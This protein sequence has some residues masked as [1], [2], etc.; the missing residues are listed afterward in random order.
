MKNRPV[1]SPPALLAASII[2][3]LSAASPLQAQQ[4]RFAEASDLSENTDAVSG[5]RATT[6]APVLVTG[7][8][9]RETAAGG[10]SPVIVFEREAI[11]RVGVATLQQFFE[12]LP[13]NFGGGA[14]GANVANLGLDRDTG[15]NFGQGTSI[16]LR[17]LGTGTTL[18]LINGH[19]IA[20]SNRYQYVDVSLIP[21]S[22]VERVE[23]LTDGASAIYGADAV[24]GVVNIILRRDFTGYE[25]A[26]RAGATTSGGMHEYQVSQAGGWAWDGGHLLASYEF[27]KQD[28]LSA[29][30]RDFSKDV[31]VKPYDLYPGSKRHSLYVDGAQQLTDAL[32]LTVTGSFAKR[33]MDTTI[34]GTTDETRLFPQTRQFD[35]FAGLTLD[36]P[37]QWQARLNGGYGRNTVR[38][39]RT[40]IAGT[41]AVTARPTDMR[42]DT[43]YLELIADG[44][45]MTLPAGAARAAVGTSIRRDSYDFYD[46]R[47]LEKPFDVHRNITSAFGELNVPLLKDLPGLRK[48]SL[49]AALR[50]DD[51]SDFGSTLNPKLGLLWEATEGLTL[52][53]TYGR[54]HRAPVYQDMQPNNTAVVANIP[55]PNAP[56]GRT[57]LLMLANGNP[58]LAA[59]RAKTWTGGLT[60]APVA[61]PGLKIDA[62]YY[63]VTYE[64]RIDSGFAGSFPS[65]FLGP[66]AAYSDILTFAPTPEQIQNARQIGLAGLGVFVSRV[67]PFALAPGTDETNTEVILDN[68]F[69]NNASTAQ[70]G[71]DLDA[72]YVFDAGQT[73]IALNL[74]GQYI[75]DST[76]R[77]TSTAP[78]VD[79]FNAVY[80]P[81][82]LKLRG[83]VAITRRQLSGGVF[84]NY[85]DH[86]R[87]PANLV[88]PHVA[89]WTTVD[90]NIG[91]RFGASTR[92]QEG[93]RL[94]LNV[95]N[96]FDR[97]PP[98]VINGI[99]TG[100]D[101]TNATALGRF[102]SMT[103]THQW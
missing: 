81:I 18:T 82:D 23:I 6:L 10:A 75:I 102:A 49:T 47:G 51:Y 48:L 94:A 101:P 76:R 63:R 41:S 1:V 98:F 4:R 24:G 33:D 78:E 91:Y 74:A 54:S 85:A 11:E 31:T 55:N 56:T 89:S 9:I 7:S 64:D 30:D 79:A 53:G 27:L 22:A 17:G 72:S 3:L 38:Y 14:N 20:S 61:V 5:S 8:H 44:E 29:I 58:D 99:N 93:T 73:N 87:D 80:L 45:W 15:N 77:V 40:T 35:L 62:S 69:R 100:F 103:L 86:Y 60:F 21:L 34:S 70:R 57:V 39:E 19:R 84:V 36:L 26:V 71:V 28:N 65:L 88:D 66:T 32:M 95:Q 97:D 59:E 96:L 68:R 43:R 67:G 42:S 13:Q 46:Y 90:L 25:S 50:Y 37:R 52:R 83:G 2:A 92:S 12:K 16:N